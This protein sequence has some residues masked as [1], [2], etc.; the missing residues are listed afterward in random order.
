MEHDI[1]NRSS[2][3]TTTRGLLHCP[4]I[5]WTS[6]RKLLKIG[7]SFLSMLRKF[8]ILFHCQASQT[9]ISKRNSIKLCQTMDRKS[10]Y[11]FAVEKSGLS[12]P[13]KIGGQKT[14]TSVHF[15]ATSRLNGEYLLKETWHRQSARALES[16]R[17]PYIVRKF[18]EFW[19][20]NGLK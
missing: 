14:V 18:H 3:L 15:S 6:V 9:E 17:I 2:A 5:L 4:K 16:T 8:C 20:T 19:S 11:Q 10:R 1:D 13:N 7:P 12:L